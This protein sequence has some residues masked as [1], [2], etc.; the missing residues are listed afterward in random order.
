MKKKLTGKQIL[1]ILGLLILVGVYAASFLCAIFARPET[2]GMFMASLALTIIVPILMYL[3]L[4]M[5]KNR[6]G[7]KGEMSYTEFKSYNKRLKQ[8]E[9]ADKLAAEIEEKYNGAENAEETKKQ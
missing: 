7:K 6:E 8:G 3:L 2:M 5:M 4:L 9:D 1:A